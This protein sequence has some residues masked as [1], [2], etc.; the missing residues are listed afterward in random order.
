MTV[1]Q[2]N[3][4]RKLAWLYAIMF[5]IIASLN[6][7]PGLIDAD[8]LLFGIFQLEPHD[9]LL[10]LGSGIWAT[11]A[12]LRSTRASELYF[13]IFG[14]VYGLDG[15]LGLITGWGYLDGGIILH[16]GSPHT[17][18][19]MTRFFANLPHILIGGIAVYI[20]FVLS[21]RVARNG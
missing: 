19:L 6:Y 13:K 5:F 14:V 15:V 16:T 8:G 2:L 21:R 3:P 20:G 17:H 4:L 1:S 18:D 11:I 7:I 12:A 9:D 10:H